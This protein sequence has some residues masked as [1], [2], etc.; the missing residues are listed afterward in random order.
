MVFS[1]IRS[2]D[3]RYTD[4]WEETARRISNRDFHGNFKEKK[5]LAASV[6][7]RQPEWN[8]NMKKHFKAPIASLCARV[9]P[10]AVYCRR[11]YRKES[12]R[13][14][15]QRRDEVAA[16]EGS[17][18]L[19]RGW[20]NPRAWLLHLAS[21]IDYLNPPTTYSGVCLSFPHPPS[22]NPD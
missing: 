8:T 9:A 2:R 14:E 17:Q 20:V 3:P 12:E 4:E 11:Y 1:L 22:S 19:E 21:S 5:I 10:A 6:I 15:C 7:S 18:T 13:Q 16:A